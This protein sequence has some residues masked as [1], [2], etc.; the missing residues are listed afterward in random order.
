MS[1]LS[2][3]LVFALGGDEDAPLQAIV[4]I[5][6]VRTGLSR[7][8]L[9]FRSS[10]P[11]EEPEQRT[12]MEKLLA[13]LLAPFDDLELALQ[14]VLQLRSIYTARGIYQ[15]QIGKLVGQP[16]N[17]LGDDDY[18]RF[19]FARI[20]T[21]RSNGRRATLI[22]IAKLLL[23]DSAA[24]VVIENAGS[25][26][27]VIRIDGGVVSNALAAILLDFLQ[28]AAPAGVRVIFESSPDVLADQ[29]A[30]P[31]AAFA[32]AGAYTAGQT[33]IAVNST[34][35]FPTTGSLVI[36]EGTGNEEQVDYAGTTATT[37]SLST[38]LTDNHAIRAAVA[39]V[40]PATGQGFGTVAEGENLVPYSNVGTI[41]GTLIDAR[42]VT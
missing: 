15:D 20:K 11:M 2:T 21:N 26:N 10:N 33:T 40:E 23:N 19:L 30:F 25:A 7:L 37:F 35:G 17:G 29:F 8:C 16:R 32:T 27:A 36:D 6:H 24:H 31:A 14:Q 28:T 5:D 3:E 34:A 1:S 18:R 12:N 22:Q 42:E 41:G 9:Q 4:T 13:C 39:L 38:P